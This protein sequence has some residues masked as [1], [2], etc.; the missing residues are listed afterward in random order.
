MSNNFDNNFEQDTSAVLASQPPPAHHTHQSSDPIRT[1]GPDYSAEITNDSSMWG[2]NNQRRFGAG[3]DDHV[4]MGGG[5]H[6]A[7]SALPTS[8]LDERDAGHKADAFTE[9]RPMNVQPTGAG[10]VAVD[11]RDDLP[12]G[13]AKITDKL[14]GKTQKVAG[15]MM[16]KPEMHE[17]GELREAGGK[18]AAAGR[19]RAPH[20]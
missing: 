4:V 16:H 1:A 9:D 17:K 11:G 8:A 2:G 5:Q 14:I 13:K 10:G 7:D 3:T 18:D 15:K 6:A 19:A 12:E 20:D